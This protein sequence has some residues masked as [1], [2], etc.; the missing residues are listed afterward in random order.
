MWGNVWS[1]RSSCC[2]N[3]NSVVGVG[4]AFSV[5][6]PPL[7]CLPAL[8]M[9]QATHAYTVCPT[10]PLHR[11]SH[12]ITTHTSYQGGGSA[13]RPAPTPTSQPSPSPHVLYI[14]S[15]ARAR[16]ASRWG[17]GAVSSEVSTVL[18]CWTPL[19]LLMGA[20]PTRYACSCAPNYALYSSSHTLSLTPSPKLCKAKGVESGAIPVL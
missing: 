19:Y 6:L 7:G 3:T 10:M 20:F 15:R 16:Y 8:S 18:R 14:Y 12:D 2:A 11:T 5:G 17:C 1:P 9:W 4:C 13:L